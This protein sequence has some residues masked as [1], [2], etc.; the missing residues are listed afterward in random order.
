MKEDQ[1]AIDIAQQ[2]IKDG[3]SNQIA[4]NII[5]LKDPKEMWDKLKSIC[6][7]VNQGVIYS[8]FQEMLHYPKITK[9]K[10]YK[11]LVI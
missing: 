11:K 6:I 9:P 1:M 5:D 8:I 10:G 7:E 2:I 4:F 3:V